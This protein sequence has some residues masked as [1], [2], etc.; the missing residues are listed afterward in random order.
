MHEFEHYS[1][2]DSESLY[3]RLKALS[4]G[5]RFIKVHLG[6][7]SEE[8]GYARAW[9]NRLLQDLEADGFIKVDQDL[10]SA[11]IEFPNESHSNNHTR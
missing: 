8:R 2:D 10:H 6:S 5:Q 3:L 7:L 1:R 11:K 4:K 9:I